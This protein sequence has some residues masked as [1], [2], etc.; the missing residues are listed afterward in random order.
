MGK[1]RPHQTKQKYQT[2]LEWKEE[3]FGTHEPPN[4]KTR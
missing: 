2:L 3:E 4:P 1:K